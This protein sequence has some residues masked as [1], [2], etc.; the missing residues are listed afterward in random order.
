[1]A[2]MT[3]F[4]FKLDKS[5]R[6]FICP[7]CGKREFVKYT[8]SEGNY[9][10]DEFGR[11]DREVNCGYFQYPA[12][13][14]TRTF[15]T[16][17]IPARKPQ[18]FF[19]KDVF[20]RTLKASRNSTF[21]ANLKALGIPEE[22]IIKTFED[23][24][25]GG[26]IKGK[27]SGGV[28]F[29]YIDKFARIHSVQVKAFNE[30]NKTADQTWL[31]SIMYHHYKPSG[32]IPQW[33]TDYYQNEKKTNCLFGEHLLD[34]YNSKDIIIAESPKNAILGSFYLPEYLWLASGT[35]RTLS[36]EKL[37]KL[38]GRKI[39]LIPD[40]SKENVAFAEWEYIMHEAT[41]TGLNVRMFTFLEE[42]TTE[43]QKATG[44]DIAD[45]ITDLL[46][47]DPNLFHV[48]APNPPAKIKR[49]YS[50]TERIKVGLNF[51]TE[52]LQ[53]LA[54]KI[55]PEYSSITQNEITDLLFQIEG[56]TLTDA[57]DLLLVMRMKNILDMTNQNRY[58]LFNSTPY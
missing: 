51:S 52:E 35:L 37:R 14:E 10:S 31:H 43:E 41:E 16:C 30:E 2:T 46:K 55:I 12:N 48:T 58:F 25:I 1:M 7:Q 24:K 4:R 57:T 45:Y 6:K 3:N 34:Q 33:I 56:L 28:T 15:E 20:E 21:F 22:T 40:T 49:E 13:D 39:L 38:K 44:Y 9:Q 23:Y 53:Q 17:I 19:P 54:E 5:S 26:L 27:Y 18:I 47:V 42:N 50:E 29:P 36:V 11:C 8:D 32:N